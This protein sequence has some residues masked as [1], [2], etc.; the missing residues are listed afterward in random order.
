M[1]SE[2]V[3]IVDL[4]RISDLRGNLSV[5]SRGEGIDFEPRRC[6]WL[7]DVPGGESRDGHAY[8]HS[9]ELIVAL[10]GSFK[11]TAV[12]P[13]GEEE[14]FVLD[15]PDR[16]LL[17]PAMIWRELSAFTTNATALIIASTDYDPAD[18]I[19]DIDQFKLIATR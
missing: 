16:G 18:Y 12:D 7:N 3:R 2:R 1:G 4:K 13:C 9:R 19:R 14:S 5:V 15:R 6:Y 17:V 11:V 8:R 10:S